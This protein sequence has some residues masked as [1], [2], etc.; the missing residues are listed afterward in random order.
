MKFGGASSRRTG[1]SISAARSSCLARARTFAASAAVPEGRPSE[2]G[3]SGKSAKE[4]LATS[5][6]M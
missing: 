3:T 5:Q 6:E 2:E 1:N 4:A